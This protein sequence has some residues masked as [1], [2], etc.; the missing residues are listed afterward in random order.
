MESGDFNEIL[1]KFELTQ[2][3]DMFQPQTSIF[4]NILR[5]LLLF[6]SILLFGWLFMSNINLI[7]VAKTL[8]EAEI[9]SEVGKVNAFTNIDRLK[10]FTIEKI[11]YLEVIRERFSENAMIRIVV[12]SVLV[13]IQIALYAMRGNFS[14]SARP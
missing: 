3:T 7:N 13:I 2:N 14:G 1:F 6:V 4:M 10:E 12:I 5:P 11:N 8:N 9:G